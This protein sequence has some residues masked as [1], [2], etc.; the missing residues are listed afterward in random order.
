M[1]KIKNIWLPRSRVR[2]F[3]RSSPLFG[4]EDIDTNVLS[5]LRRRQPNAHVT[6]WMSERPD[7]W[8]A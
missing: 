6:Q 1:T 2:E 5:E 7:P 3:M 8:V 4:A